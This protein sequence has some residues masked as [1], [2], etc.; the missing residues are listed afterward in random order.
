MKKYT[1]MAIA[2][3]ALVSIFS[4]CSDEPDKSNFYTFKGQM[5]SQ[6]LQN[7]E[8]FSEFTAIVERAGFMD[9]L[10]TYGAYTC[11][12]PTN[13]AVK[14][15]LENRG[16]SSVYELS[17]AD[18]DTITRT[19]L[20]NN[21]YALADMEDGVLSTANMNRRYIEVTHGEDEYG[22]P[23]VFLNGT[24]HIIFALR[25]DSVENGI[26]Q[27][28]SEVLESSNRMIIDVMKLNPNISLYTE[29]YIETGLVDSFYQ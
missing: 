21:V 17:L 20:V 6:Y 2:F 13:E 12:P 22:N 3:W 5:M 11:F 19:H 16:L 15:F 24:A 23:T 26:M 25:D 8:Q 18:C 10:S 1:F 7:H 28:V 4:G 14:A 29:A 9:L 27:P